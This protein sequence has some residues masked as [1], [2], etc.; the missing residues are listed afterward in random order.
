MKETLTALF[1]KTMNQELSGATNR[2]DI[3]TDEIANK[4]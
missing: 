2:R 1:E 3:I 4:I